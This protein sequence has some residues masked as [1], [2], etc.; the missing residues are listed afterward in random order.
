MRWFTNRD[1]NTK[2]F[3]A[4]VK[5][6][7]GNIQINKI[8]TRQGDLITTTQNIGKEAINIFKDQFKEPIQGGSIEMI[9]NIPHIITIQEYEK[10]KKMPSIEEV[11]QLGFSQNSR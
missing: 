2:F 7:R 4:Y 8:Q 1:G 9:T 10:I 6:K 5:E 11:K 3:H